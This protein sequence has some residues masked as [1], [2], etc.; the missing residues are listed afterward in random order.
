M[1]LDSQTLAPADALPASM[2]ERATGFAIGLAE[3]GRLPDAVVRAGIRQM[4]RERETELARLGP[5]ES[6]RAEAAF[7]RECTTGP[8]ALSP[9]LANEQ[10]YEVPPAFFEHVL[11]PHRK[12]SCCLYA[13]AAAGLPEAE[14]AMLELT[15]E[16]AGIVDGMT[17]LDLGCGWGSFS[18]WAAERFPGCRILAVSN[19]QDQRGHIQASARARGL[20]NVEVVTADMNEFDPGRRVDRV[21]SVEMFE[22]MRNWPQLLARIASWLAPD[23]R[24]FVHH[25]CHRTRAYPY[26]ARG[27]SN[28]MAEHFFTG[29]MMPSDAWILNFQDDLRVEARW[30]VDGWHYQR[31]CEDWLRNL[32]ASRGDILPILKET[33]GDANAELWL[34]RWRI[35]FLSCAELFGYRGGSE[36]WVAHAR[37]AP[38]V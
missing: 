15:S 9:E 13:G 20:G 7:L 17:I 33:Y 36:W 4:L 34:Q 12:Y 3:R 19:S 27:A 18:L 25:F 5:D 29:G 32:D 38:R 16:R 35:F 30:R 2:L 23:G 31:T 24:V 26:V 1:A 6:L 10:H 14:I 21:V 8:I 28:W 22:H 11:G 37:L